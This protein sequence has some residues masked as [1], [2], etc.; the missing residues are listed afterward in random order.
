MKRFVIENLD[1][2]KLFVEILMMLAT[3]MA[4]FVALYSTRIAN[5]KSIRIKSFVKYPYPNLDK[6]NAVIT[7]TLSNTGNRDLFI[8]S[9]GVVLKNK[10]VLQFVSELSAGLPFKLEKDNTMDLDIPVKYLLNYLV[11]YYNKNLIGNFG[12]VKFYVKDKAGDTY[13]VNL[14]G[15]LSSWYKEYGMLK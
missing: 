12:K 3:F 10:K 5:K 14:N 15:K 9:W 13:Y 4:S 2:I 1:I 8:E 6:N 11:E 7:I